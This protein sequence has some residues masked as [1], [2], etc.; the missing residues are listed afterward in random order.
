MTT[1]Q[2]PEQQKT[3]LKKNLEPDVGVRVEI[4]A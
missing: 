4:K 3:G 1:R 2:Q